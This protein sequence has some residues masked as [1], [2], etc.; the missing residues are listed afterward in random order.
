MLRVGLTGGIGCGKSTVAAIMA[1]LGCHLVYADKIAHQAI[2]PGHSAYSEVVSEFGREVLAPD[3]S[4]DRPRL[5]SVVFADP[6]RLARLNAI[7]HP[8]VL[9]EEDRQLRELERDH[10][11]GVAVVEAAL[12]IEAGFYKRLDRLVVAW[13]KPEQQL[14]RLTDASYGRS[15]S[16]QDAQRRIASQLSL[17]EKLRL[18]DDA[19][20]C[21][22]SLEETQR[23]VVALVERLKKLAAAA[24]P[25]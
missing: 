11:N 21:S 7:V 13:C 17:D 4:V 20:D 6:A 25:R 2:E 9:E 14:A 18:A 24:A 22:G 12:L 8:R 19:I 10:P 1:G 3:Q 16:Q 15:M 5:A 23:Q